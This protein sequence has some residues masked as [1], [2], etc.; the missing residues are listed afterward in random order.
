MIAIPAI[1]LREGACVQLVGG[2]FEHE[3]IRL[4]DPVGAARRWRAA[5]FSRLHVVD[6]DAAAG[7]GAN[8]DAI[9]DIVGSRCARVSV[10]GGVRTS[11]R[12]AQLLDSGAESVVVGT[13]AL[14][15]P[16]WL[17]GIA[18]EHP[19]R[20]I[21]ALDVR[22]RSVVIDAWTRRV[23]TPLDELARRLDALPL[24]GLLVT[25]VHREG[26]LAGPDVALVDD[27]G[28]MTRHPV[29]ASGGISTLDD[30]RAVE[31]RGAAA[32]VIGMALYSGT[33]DA[34]AVAAE[35]NT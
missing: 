24:A 26:L 35:F 23:E 17:V 22:E 32:C 33:L 11:D 10:G 21:V 5:G 25:A 15:D 27:V 19:A 20:I 6:L 34:S 28:R 4:P 14:E 12:V 9:N 30:L 7:I 31:Q 3:R 1:D 8:D 29:I 18:D 13:R 16:D 2:S